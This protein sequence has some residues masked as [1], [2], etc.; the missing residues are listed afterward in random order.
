[1][2]RYWRSGNKLPVD[3]SRVEAILFGKTPAREQR[4][5]LRAAI[6]KDKLVRQ[7]AGENIRIADIRFVREKQWTGYDL[8]AKVADLDHVLIEGLTD[9]DEAP[10]EVLADA[11]LDYPDTWRLV[12]DNFDRI[13]GYW[14]F[15][16]LTEKW[17]ERARSG[18]LLDK[19]LALETMRHFWI[20][21]TYDIHVPIMGILPEH[22]NARGNR[23]LFVSFMDVLTDLAKA[24][25]FIG[26]VCATAF[27]VAGA[28]LCQMLG[29]T[30]LREHESRGIVFESRMI[31][32][33][34]TILERSP[35]LLKN[36]KELVRR[37]TVR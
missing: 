2:E 30:R 28:R 13:V 26:R 17:Y 11:Y 25:I 15:V 1:M 22:R 5:E 7:K 16:P 6:D 27:T 4:L 20:P 29:M 36:H 31:D 10:P 33:I 9:D 35:S 32:I 34:S 18:T 8:A 37:Y 3:P 24:D 14:R 23:L 12:V 21:G 19:E